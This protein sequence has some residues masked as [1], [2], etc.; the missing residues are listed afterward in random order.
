MLSQMQLIR[1]ACGVLRRMQ[2]STAIS[3]ALPS[4]LQLA[5]GGR[6]LRKEK[7][8]PIIQ[9]PEEHYYFPPLHAEISTLPVKDWSSP[10]KVVQF[11][12]PDSKTPIDKHF[13]LS[14]VVFNNAIR[15]DLVHDVIRQQRAK[16]RQPHKTKRVGEISGSTRKPWPQKGGNRSQA[17]HTRNSTWRKGMKVHGPVIRDFGFSLNK[18]TR[19]LAMIAVLTAKH[20]EGNLHIFNTVD[21]P[22]KKTKDL[23]NIVRSHGLLT[24]PRIK[25]L[26]SGT[27]STDTGKIETTEEG[28]HVGR[29]WRVMFVCDRI[30]FNMVYASQNVQELIVV[31]ETRLKLLD[32]VRFDV[33]AI[34]EQAMQFLQVRV[35]QQYRNKPRIVTMQKQHTIMTAHAITQK[36]R[37]E[38]EKTQQAVARQAVLKAEAEGK[39]V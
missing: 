26:A 35:E 7:A 12:P 28:S 15:R 2:S 34:S 32:L 19:A 4:N 25:E 14:S 33:L 37:A 29:Q 5:D 24:P 27:T 10:G 17:G 30:G 9:I 18:K 39:S 38:I 8:Q 6:I 3:A 13:E 36:M 22:T 16:I 20:R 21:T 11:T 31:P 1:P 23:M